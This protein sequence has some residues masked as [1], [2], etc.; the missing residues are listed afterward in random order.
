M[1]Q[2][3]QKHRNNRASDGHSLPV[4]HTGCKKSGHGTTAPGMGAHFLSTSGGVSEGTKANRTNGILTSWR[5]HQEGQVS[6]RKKNG[7]SEGHIPTGDRRGMHRSQHGNKPRKRGA[8]TDW[9]EE[10]VQ[11][12]TRKQT[13]R[14]RYSQTGECKGREKSGHRNNRLSEGNSLPGEHRERNK[15]GHGNKLSERGALTI[16]RVRRER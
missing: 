12:R 13:E 1:S 10:K 5:A 14:A 6:T 16:W 8:L 9:R 2:D 3:A 7:V 4:E 15:S 11:V